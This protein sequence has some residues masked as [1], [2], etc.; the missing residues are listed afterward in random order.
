MVLRRSSASESSKRIN[1]Q[2]YIAIVYIICVLAS[3]S[4]AWGK[5]CV[6]KASVS[7]TFL[8]IFPGSESA[9]F[10]AILQGILFAPQKC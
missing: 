7:A 5:V 1:H 6:E 2:S 3:Y 8:V 4:L 10:L 9:E